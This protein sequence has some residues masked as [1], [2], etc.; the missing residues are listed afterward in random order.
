M[1]KVTLTLDT[2]ALLQNT[3]AVVLEISPAD[4]GEDF[5][6]FLGALTQSAGGQPVLI[7][8]T[9]QRPEISDSVIRQLLQ[10]TTGTAGDRS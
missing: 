2:T 4:L 10:R 3:G 6:T 7:L 9:G 1:T 8:P 5:D